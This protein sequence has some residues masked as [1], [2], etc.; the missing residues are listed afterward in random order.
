MTQT[1]GE[2]PPHEGGYSQGGYPP[3]SQPAGYPPQSQPG[4]YSTQ[5]Q[6]G[7]YPPQPPGGYPPQGQPG[8]YPGQPGGYN[9]QGGY[10]PGAYPG[11]SAGY[12]PGAGGPPPKKSRATIIGI[13]A[14]AVLLLAAIGGVILVLTQGGDT[15]PDATI[16]P[17]P[18][19]EPTAEAPSAQPTSASPSGRQSTPLQPTGGPNPVPSGEAISLDHGISLTPADGYQLEKSGTGYARLSNGDQLFLGQAIAVDPGTNPEQLCD[20][21]HRKITEGQANGQFGNPETA[22]LN[23]KNLEGATCTGMFTASNGSGSQDVVVF[24]LVSVRSDGVTAIGTMYLSKDADSDQLNK[25]FTAM[26][27][28]MLQDQATGG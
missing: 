16:T 20:A 9:P 6:S 11:A 25:D 19:A 1:P 24:S 12:P 4:G 7:G 18:T 13:V 15:Q 8:S 27:N 26:M 14:A 28:S 21:W 3:Q 22:D 23:T 10:P 5:P 2:W 17:T